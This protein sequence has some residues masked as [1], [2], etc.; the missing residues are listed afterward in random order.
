MSVLLVNFEFVWAMVTRILLIN[1]NDII[2]RHDG[3]FGSAS[4]DALNRCE[5]RHGIINRSPGTLPSACASCRRH[6]S[7][8]W[9]LYCHSFTLIQAAIWSIFLKCTVDKQRSLRLQEDGFITYCLWDNGK[10]M[11]NLKPPAWLAA[12]LANSGWQ[13]HLLLTRSSLPNGFLQMRKTLFN[14]SVI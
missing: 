6:G 10:Q 9:R 13:T 2:C 11:W 12:W 14:T 1:F 5:F 7:R 3:S 4:A 8:F